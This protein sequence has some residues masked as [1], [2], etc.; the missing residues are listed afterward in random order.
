MQKNHLVYVFRVPKLLGMRVVTIVLTAFL[1]TAMS[2]SSYAQNNQRNEV[3]GVITDEQG[4][5]VI[6]ANVIEVGTTNGTV[7]DIDGNFSID[8]ASGASISISY[9][10]YK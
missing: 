5:P 2:I 4:L 8:V 1:M 3:S 10:G 7:T 9:I 6:G